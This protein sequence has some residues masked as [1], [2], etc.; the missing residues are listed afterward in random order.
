ML[1]S[2]GRGQAL[3]SLRHGVLG[4]LAVR[5]QPGQAGQGGSSFGS[6]LQGF[7]LRPKSRLIPG[8]VPSLSRSELEGPR[9]A[10]LLGQIRASLK[11]TGIPGLVFF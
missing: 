6:W 2:Q 1:I 11:I 10:Q 5:D 7:F 4:P 8:K 9:F 3:N